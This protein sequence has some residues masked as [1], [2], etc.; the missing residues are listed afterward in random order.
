MQ[1]DEGLAAGVQLLAPLIQAHGFAFVTLAGGQGSGGWRLRGTRQTG[2]YLLD[3]SHTHRYDWEV[4]TAAALDYLASRPEVDTDRIAYMGYSWGGYFVP[5]A[6]AFEKHIAACVGAC[7]LPDVYTPVVRTMG[8]EQLLATGSAVTANQLTT[9]QRYALVEGMPRFGFP[10]GA[11][12]LP[13]WG[14]MIKQMNLWGLEDK[15]TCPV[16]NISTTGEGKDMYEIARTFFDALP[17]PLN[18]FV[19]TTEEEGAELHTVRGNS[20]LLHQIEF[21]WLDEVMAT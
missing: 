13:A 9:K 8:V 18:R 4:P 14:E 6:A 16:L 1:A 3:P 21:D 12:D 19:L 17:N 15:I 2:A 20:S 11:E 5:R 7:L 10:N